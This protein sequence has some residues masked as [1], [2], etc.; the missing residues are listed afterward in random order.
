MNDAVE[1]AGLP[2]HHQISSTHRVQQGANANQWIGRG[3]SVSPKTGIG[4]AAPPA[5]VF[6]PSAGLEYKTARARIRTQLLG[7]SLQIMRPAQT[8]DGSGRRFSF[9]DNFDFRLINHNRPC[10]AAQPAVTPSRNSILFFVFLSLFNTSSIAST[11]GTPVSARR[12]MTTFAYS[13]GW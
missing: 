4:L 2:A 3:H 6:L 8:V 7:V 5:L 11:G 13:C 9:P 12:S 10:S 1:N